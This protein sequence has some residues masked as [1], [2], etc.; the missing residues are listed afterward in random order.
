MSLESVIERLTSLKSFDVSRAATVHAHD[1]S[2]ALDAALVAQLKAHAK[3]SNENVKRAH[4]LLWARLA[5]RQAATRLASLAAL[6]VIFVRSAYARQLTVPALTDLIAL[7]VGGDSH[8][9]VPGANSLKSLL[10]DAALAALERWHRDH[11]A[12]YPQLAVSLAFVRDTL[13][14]ELPSLAAARAAAAAEARAAAVQRR[15]H[16][17]WVQLAPVIEARL[18]ELEELVDEMERGAALLVPFDDAPESAASTVAPS[19]G[20]M[21][22][23]DQMFEIDVVVDT[24]EPAV[25]ESNDNNAVFATLRERAAVLQRWLAA[26][27]MVWEVTL[28]RLEPENATVAAR[29]NE[30][31]L[32]LLD[33][34]TSARAALQQCADM[35]VLTN[36]DD[37]DDEQWEDPPQKDGFEQ[38]SV[39]ER[40]PPIRA[41]PP[42]SPRELEKRRKFK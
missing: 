29:R 3:A 18:P 4:E 33:V 1:W 32:Q 20:D 40:A 28:T 27:A 22:M 41:R 21:G 14:V 31:L 12:L 16:A 23:P 24:T 36:D 34:K 6:D 15:L 17:K 37:D 11:V 38:F 26:D 25:R 8:R 35:G 10:R 13:R 9:P 30:L 5:S 42:N 19:L 2:S 39:V 7:T